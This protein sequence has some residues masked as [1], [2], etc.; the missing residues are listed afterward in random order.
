MRVLLFILLILLIL[1]IAFTAVVILAKY[2]PKIITGGDPFST[3]IGILYNENV[4]KHNE[5]KRLLIKYRDLLELNH[6]VEAQPITDYIRTLWHPGRG[7]TLWE[8]EEWA[9]VL[10]NMVVAA[11]IARRM[12]NNMQGPNKFD[13]NFEAT[14]MFGFV[15]WPGTNMVKKYDLDKTDMLPAKYKGIVYFQDLPGWNQADPKA[16]P[17]MNVGNYQNPEIVPVAYDGTRFVNATPRTPAAT[18]A[19]TPAVYEETMSDEISDSI[20]PKSN[21]LQALQAEYVN[22]N[23]VLSYMLNKAANAGLTIPDG[24]TKK[25]QFPKLLSEYSDEPVSKDYDKMMDKYV[26]LYKEGKLPALITLS[27][28]QKGL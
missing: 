20:V 1:I 23:K 3:D 10:N 15:I 6:P 21:L 22:E 26:E 24:A 9:G 14:R 11:R 27:D 12:L 17:I 8:P 13:E 5:L 19:A 7:S 25:E 16:F 2:G 4:D 18:P 28:L